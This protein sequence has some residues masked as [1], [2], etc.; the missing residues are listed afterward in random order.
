MIP[1]GYDHVLFILAL[2]FLNSEL[3]S[4]IIQCSVFTLAHSITFFLVMFNAIR[5]N[6]SITE[7]LIALSIV[8]VGIENILKPK[9]NWIRLLLIFIF[10]LVH[11]L[12][13][14]SVLMDVGLSE[15]NFLTGLLGFNL[16]VEFAQLLI[17]IGLY[18]CFSKWFRFK[19]WYKVSFVNSVSVC[20][21]CIG[22]FWSI[23][24]FLNV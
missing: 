14:A 3:K 8:V 16:G 20:I 1:G 10:G 17:V 18:F 24:R 4:G 13:F 5:F 15:V 23:S 21:S 19:N 12:G 7:T 9:L 2:F 22:L 11:G 6:T